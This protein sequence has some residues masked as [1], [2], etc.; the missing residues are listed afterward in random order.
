MTWNTLCAC[1]GTQYVQ[2]LS[3]VWILYIFFPFLNIYLYH[4]FLS[5]IL[6]FI[7]K[8]LY[9]CLYRMKIDKAFYFNKCCTNDSM[10]IA[11]ISI[12]NYTVNG[13]IDLSNTLHLLLYNRLEIS[14]SFFF[15]FFKIPNRGINVSAVVQ[16]PKYF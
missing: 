10:K 9:T 8:C 1:K 14:N 2:T 15:F 4:A 7:C 11:A 13:S 6:L 16:W 12:V 3:S 5:V